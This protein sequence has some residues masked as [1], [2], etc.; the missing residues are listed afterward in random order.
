MFLED[1][2]ETGVIEILVVLKEDERKIEL[3]EGEFEFLQSRLKA[4]SIM[5]KDDEVEDNKPESFC[6]VMFVS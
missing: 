1:L 6:M 2:T 4:K 5:I 3:G